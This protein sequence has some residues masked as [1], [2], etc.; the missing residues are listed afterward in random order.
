MKVPD[1]CIRTSKAADIPALK[2][3]WHS[4]FGDMFPEIDMFFDTFFEEKH[5]IVAE[6]QSTLAAMGFL[7]PAGFLHSHGKEDIKCAMIY[8][9]ATMPSMRNLGCGVKITQGLLEAAN[10][11]GYSAVVL[12]P[13]EESLFDFYRIKSGMETAF[14]CNEEKISLQPCSDSSLR[15]VSAAEYIEIRESI[16]NNL[17]HITFNERCFEYQEFLCGDG[18]LFTTEG[19][20]LSCAIVEVVSG[21][22]RVIELLGAG[23]KLIQAIATKYPAEEYIVRRLGTNLQFGMINSENTVQNAWFGP[24]FD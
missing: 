3:L 4:V 1:I 5:C 2:I 20:K 17:P 8:A 14:F 9:V 10:S 22:I 18:G 15:R 24:A 23:E 13:A 11:L 12:H 21:T 19:D 6:S 16:L 7:L